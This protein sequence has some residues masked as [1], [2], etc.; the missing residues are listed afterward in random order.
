MVIQYLQ[1]YILYCT[2]NMCQLSKIQWIKANEGLLKIQ[3]NTSLSKS[4]CFL[5]ASPNTVNS[6]A[7]PN[8]KCPEIKTFISPTV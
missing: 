7:Q 6:P 2:L 3:K 5:I 1:T 8:C 4:F